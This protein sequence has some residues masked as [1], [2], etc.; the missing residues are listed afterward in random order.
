VE[1]AKL[2]VEV[3]QQ[4]KIAPSFAM[5]TQCFATLIMIAGSAVLGAE[6]SAPTPPPPKP[7][8]TYPVPAGPDDGVWRLIFDGQSLT[9]WEGDSRYW[10]VEHGCIVGEVTP[11]TLLKE[12]TFLIWRG[13][14]TRD[15]ELKVEYRISERGNSGINYR[16]VPVPGLPFALAGYQADIDGQNRYTGQNYEERGRTF[17][18][19]RGQITRI[20]AGRKAEVIGSVGDAKELERFIRNGDWNEYHLIARGHTLIHVLNGHV[21]SVV[22]DEDAANRRLEGL[23]GV[24]VHVGPPMKVEYRNFRLKVLE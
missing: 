3:W 16:S 15:F 22:V 2:K 11:A 21:M 18:A 24:Q 9:G 6:N 14:V 7:K 23:L 20:P 10:R 12:N 8:Q 19:M 1:S 17:N 4:S 13:G 5:K